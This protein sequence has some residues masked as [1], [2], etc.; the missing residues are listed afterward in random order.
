MIPLLPGRHA[1]D[2]ILLEQGDEAVE[3]SAL[4]G[5]NVAL[6]KCVLLI[7]GSA[8]EL[9]RPAGNSFASVARARWRALLTDATE[10][11]SMRAVSAADQLSTSR[12][13]STARWRG[14]RC[15]IAA[16]AMPSSAASG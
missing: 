10:A 2:C 11:S 15:W 13:S 3:I 6:Q 1:E 7:A 9:G 12:S 4:P 8:W 5:S 16:S 14:G